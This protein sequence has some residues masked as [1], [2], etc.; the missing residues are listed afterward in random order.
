LQRFRA[1]IAFDRN[2]LLSGAVKDRALTF[3]ANPPLGI[4]ADA[5][6]LSGS[7]LALLA[8]AVGDKSQ[9]A[10]DFGAENPAAA[11]RYLSHDT[12]LA[13]QPAP[14]VFAA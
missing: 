14:P 7:S 8:M 12:P 10:R 9:I 1:E 5:E 13:V 4:G 11:R 2:L 3:D 6:S